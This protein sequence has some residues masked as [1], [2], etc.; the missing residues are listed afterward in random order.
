MCEL[1]VCRVCECARM[2]Q[3]VSVC[4][5]YRARLFSCIS[6]SW[7]WDVGTGSWGWDVGTGSWGWDVGTGSWGW[8]VGRTRPHDMSIVFTVCLSYT[9]PTTSSEREKLVQIDGLCSS[10]LLQHSSPAPTA[11]A[12]PSE[13]LPPASGGWLSSAY[14]G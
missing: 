9:P 3:F 1:C 12:V 5:V 14:R 4:V 2:C 13:G 7:G 10:P 11:A 8:D 6:G